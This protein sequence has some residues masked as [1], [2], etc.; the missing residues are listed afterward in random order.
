MFKCRL[1]RIVVCL[2]VLFSLQGLRYCGRPVPP[3]ASESA[4]PAAALK[5]LVP[6][7]RQ[8]R[9]LS[10]Y[11]FLIRKY[12]RSIGMDWRLLAAIIFHESK[13]NEKAVSP[14][15]AKGLMQV[16][17]IAAIHYG[18]G[19][20]DL[21][22]PETNIRLGTILLD[23]LMGQFRREGVDSADVVRFAL[24]SYNVG[25]GALSRRRAQADSLGLNT[26]EWAAVAIVFERV[27]HSTPA[28]IDAVE[29]TYEKYL[30]LYR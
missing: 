29:A 24:A 14:V 28:Y 7:N 10:R 17:D 19:D 22:D 30:S 2:L 13:F 5:W 20:V 6:S 21:F 15:G 1:F 26:N 25:G 8:E 27:D 16:M 3:V 23:D 11:D 9:R 4:C 12:A 18:M